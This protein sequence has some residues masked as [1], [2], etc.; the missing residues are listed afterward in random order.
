MFDWLFRRPPT[1]Q[2]RH[3]VS[4][5]VT[6][7]GQTTEAASVFATPASAV[8]EAFDQVMAEVD[9]P[10]E[11]KRRLRPLFVEAHRSGGPKKEIEVVNTVL[12][13]VKW[14]EGYFGALRA[15]FEAEGAFPHM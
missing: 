10:A 2:T 1:K 9:A 6:I 8:G 11:A 7:E 3:G 15:R 12:D 5:E 4:V 14:G 13:G